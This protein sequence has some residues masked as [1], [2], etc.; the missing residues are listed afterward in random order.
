MTITA[1][2]NRQTTAEAAPN[3]REVLTLAIRSHFAASNAVEAKRQ[4][5]VR[6]RANITDIETRLE[7][8]KKSIAKAAQRDAERAAAALDAGRPVV[9]GAASTEKAEKAVVE[10]ERSIAVAE[11]ARK[12]LTAELTVLEDE[13]AAAANE[14]IVGVR[15]LTRPL[16]EDLLS[17]LRQCRQR[18]V[19]ITRVLA[20]LLD[21]DQRQMPR[22]NDQMRAFKASDARAAVFASIKPE[23]ERLLYGASR[24]D[25]ELGLEIAK[26][27]KAALIDMQRNAA[28]TLP[29]V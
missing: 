20:E 7:N 19:I 12:T 28:A 26:D 5:L 2:K 18:T 8:A 13:Q 14:I 21:N 27:V 6:S 10:A 29:K 17:E 11:R 4:A 1:L 24:E 3:P 25:H 22:F 15:E 23:A 16:V 9:A